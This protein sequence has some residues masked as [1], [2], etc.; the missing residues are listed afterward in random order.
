[1]LLFTP[2]E[3]NDNILDVPWAIFSSLDVYPTTIFAWP[4]RRIQCCSW[5]SAMYNH[6]VRVRNRIRDRN[7]SHS[8]Y[9]YALLE[10]D[11]RE[12]YA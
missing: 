8:H 2:S 4:E 7:L 12:P 6:M 10:Q 5:I 3:L 1:M 9:M 11:V